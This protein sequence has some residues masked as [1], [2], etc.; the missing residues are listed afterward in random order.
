MLI[1]LLF[2][3]AMSVPVG[4]RPVAAETNA[5]YCAMI[6]SASYA[7]VPSGLYS[8]RENVTALT[9]PDTG[10]GHCEGETYV[11]SVYRVACSGCTAHLQQTT[12]R[13]NQAAWAFGGQNCGFFPGCSGYRTHHS[14]TFYWPPLVKSLGLY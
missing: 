8:F 10:E 5:F 11:A 6:T 2:V 12:S 14:S 4:A 9:A 3:V 7:I 1:L 13:F